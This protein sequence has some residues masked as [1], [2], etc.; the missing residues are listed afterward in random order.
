MEPTTTLQK[1]EL[2][3]QEQV[4]RQKLAELRDKGIEPYPAKW[5]RTHVAGD[6]QEKYAQLANGEETQDVVRVAGRII[7]RRESGKLNFI[8]LQDGT[9]K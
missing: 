8:D 9:G 6:L 3:E 4:R 5:E 2:S 1:A 7:G